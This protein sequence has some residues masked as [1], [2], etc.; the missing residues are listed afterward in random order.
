MFGKEFFATSVA[1]PDPYVFGPPGSASGSGSHKYVSAFHSKI[2]AVRKPLST[3]LR[4]LYDFT[5]VPDPSP[6]PD[7]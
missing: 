7:P 6:D 2:V 5:S 3:V 4:L 1:D